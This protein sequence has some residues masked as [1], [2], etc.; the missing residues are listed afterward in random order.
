MVAMRRTERHVGM[1]LVAAVEEGEALAAG[2][3]PVGQ[4]ALH[5]AGALEQHVVH[6]A[7]GLAVER[8]G[9]GLA[10]RADA[11]RPRRVLLAACGTRGVSART[12]TPHHH[13]LRHQTWF[14][15]ARQFIQ[16]NELS[17]GDL[18]QV[19]VEG[20]VLDVVLP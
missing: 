6:V 12:T 17:R 11:A 8:D 14:Y 19:R 2:G 9:A 20:H 10:R 18:A 4:Q 13:T 16:R 3:A 7:V 1:S 5:Q 15:F